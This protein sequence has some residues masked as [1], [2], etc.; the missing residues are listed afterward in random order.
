MRVIPYQELGGVLFPP[1]SVADSALLSLEKF[2]L[3]VS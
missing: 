3:G 2:M 1:L